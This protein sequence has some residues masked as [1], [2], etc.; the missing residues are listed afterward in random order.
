[1]PMLA[2]PGRLE[3][4]EVSVALLIWDYSWAGATGS[5]IM[6]ILEAPDPGLDSAVSKAVHIPNELRRMSFATLLP[7]LPLW[8]DTLV[9]ERRSK[10]G[11]SQAR[12]VWSRCS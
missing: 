6:G 10:V 7:I 12:R 11:C 8:L 3:L 1:M 9:T 5:T 4:G 2:T